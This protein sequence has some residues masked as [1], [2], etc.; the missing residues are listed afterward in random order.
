MKFEEALKYLVNKGKT[1]GS[2]DDGYL[3]DKYESPKDLARLE[4]Y[5]IAYDWKVVEWIEKPYEKAIVELVNGKRIRSVDDNGKVLRVY[6]N[7]TELPKMTM[8]EV[9]EGTWEVSQ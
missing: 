9:E 4:D 2:Y 1:I 7:I 6:D 5:E 3:Y 8:D